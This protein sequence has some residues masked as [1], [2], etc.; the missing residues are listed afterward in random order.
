MPEMVMYWTLE[1]SAKIPFPTSSVT[2][3]ENKGE[4]VE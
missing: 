1:K 2:F 4:R 3:E